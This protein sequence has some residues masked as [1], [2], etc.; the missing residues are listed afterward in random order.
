MVSFFFIP[1]PTFF[2]QRARY[3]THKFCCYSLMYEIFREYCSIKNLVCM[4]YIINNSCSFF[5]CCAFPLLF[6]CTQ[7]LFIHI[8][9]PFSSKQIFWLHLNFNFIYI[10]SINVL[11]TFVIL[12]FNC[13]KSCLFM[14]NSSFSHFP[15]I[16]FMKR[17][18]L[19]DTKQRCFVLIS[20]TSIRYPKFLVFL[21]SFAF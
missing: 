5:C 1:I 16:P 8:Y 19:T 4:F 2:L 10:N 17:L 20:K 21:N 11:C 7:K 13:T 12:L 18:H 9:Y 15:T 6:M 14:L 3:Y